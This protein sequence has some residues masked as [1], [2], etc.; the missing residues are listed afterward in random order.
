MSTKRA[1]PGETKA[2]TVVA[3]DPDD[4]KGALKFI[5][6]SQSDKW[7]NVLANQAFQTL[8]LKNSDKAARDQQY[9]ATVAALVGIGQET[10]LKGCSRLSCS[11][12]TML[13]WNATGAR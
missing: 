2:T 13:R 7:N 9:S 12:H 5:G 8:W 1:A 4:V 3:N 6:G 10:S 11:R